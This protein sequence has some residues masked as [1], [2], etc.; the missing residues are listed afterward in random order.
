MIDRTYLDSIGW[1]GI[2]VR[3]I[4]VEANC[5]ATPSIA[6]RMRRGLPLRVMDVAAGHGRYVLDAVSQ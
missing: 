6:V 1:R 3:K 4:H 2:R 5:C